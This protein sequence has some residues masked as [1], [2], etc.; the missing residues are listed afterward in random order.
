MYKEQSL[1]IINVYT[2]LFLYLLL[3]LLYQISITG[4]YLNKH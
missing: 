2:G 3:I 1:E 4:Q